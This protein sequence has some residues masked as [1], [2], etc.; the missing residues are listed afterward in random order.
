MKAAVAK[1]PV[2]VEVDAGN[3]SFQYYVKGIYTGKCGT[4]PDHGLVATGY[5]IQSGKDYWILKNSWSITWG[6]KGYIWMAQ[7]GDGKGLCGMYLDSAFP[8]VGEWFDWII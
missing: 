2:A 8:I 1:T 3:Q 5:S 7:T 6:N 4:R